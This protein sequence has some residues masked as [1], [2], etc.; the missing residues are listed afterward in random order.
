MAE[1]KKCN[2]LKINSIRYTQSKPNTPIIEDS[3]AVDITRVLVREGYTVLVYDPQALPQAE[4]VLGETVEYLSS[5]KECVS[6]A[7]VVL[8]ATAWDEF[9]EID[10]SLAEGALSVV[11]CWG[12]CQSDASH[13]TV[14]SAGRA[15]GCAKDEEAFSQEETTAYA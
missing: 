8:I 2:L 13:V 11:D 7:E 1:E 10:F 15:E 6:R 14:R 5:G 4:R 9:K 3:Q 12:I